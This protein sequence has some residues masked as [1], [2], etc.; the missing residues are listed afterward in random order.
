MKTETFPIETF[1][2]E[3]KAATKTETL[4]WNWYWK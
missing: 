2:A 4:E 3:L 1:I